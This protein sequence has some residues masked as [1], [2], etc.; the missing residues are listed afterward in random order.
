MSADVEQEP[1]R[2]GSRLLLLLPLAVFGLLSA[3][4]YWGLW[5]SD[6]RLPS[7]LI[8]KPFPDFALPPMKG[9]RMACPRLTCRARCP[10]SMSGPRGASPAARRTRFSWNWPKRAPSR[11]SGSTT[12]TIPQRRWLS[13]KSSAIPSPAS[14]RTGRVAIDWGVYG[15][16]E[17]FVIDVEGRIAYKHVGPFDRRALEEDILPV[18]R[19]LQAER[20]S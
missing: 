16:P 3:A 6:D 13:S 18:V 17:T 8:G 11:S 14:E 10:S 2:R 5:N 9:G 15:L 4:F 7:T 20:G 19:R 1:R 12:R